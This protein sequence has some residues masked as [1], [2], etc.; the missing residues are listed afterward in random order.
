MQLLA[1]PVAYHIVYRRSPRDFRRSRYK[2]LR[3]AVPGCVQAGAQRGGRPFAWFR[4]DRVSRL[5]VS[6]VPDR[7]YEQEKMPRRSFSA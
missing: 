6:L 4:S 1:R 7:M 3:G 2:C 5:A